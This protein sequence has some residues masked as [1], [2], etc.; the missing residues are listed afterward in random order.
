MTACVA[1]DLREAWADV[2]RRRA[3][4]SAAL[5]AYG[6]VF[7][8]WAEVSALAAP[9]DVDADACRERWSRGVPLIAEVRPDLRTEPVEALLG[10]LLG[11]VA[12]VR[13]DAAPAVEAFAAAWERGDVRPA[14]LLP[15][16]GGFGVPV[17]TGLAPDLVGFLAIGSLRP[18]LEQVFA[19]CHEHLVH[20]DWS[21]GVCPFCG[22]PPAWGDIGEDGRLE[23]ACHLCGGAWAFSRLRCPFCGTD[24]AKE[25]RRMTA[26]GPEGGYALATCTRCRAYLKSVDRRERWNAGPALVEDWGS[27]HFDVVALR[28][29]YARPLVPLVVTARTD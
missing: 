13:P 22:A 27:P 12:T 21:L 23:L 16:R 7:D 18:L 6:A 3:A 29:G 11:V 10:P 5:S 2:L 9:L 26:E 24:D 20:G 25:L 28:E 19:P 1:L 14:S 8:L 17:T 4:L 15:S